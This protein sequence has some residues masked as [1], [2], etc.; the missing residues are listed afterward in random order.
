MAPLD[1]YYLIGLILSNI[2]FFFAL[3]LFHHLISEAFDP[4]I[5]KAGLLY[6]AFYRYAIFFFA[7]YTESLFLLLCLGIFLLLRSQQMRYWWLAGVLGF[8]AT[9]TRSTGIVLMV[10]ILIVALQRYW[11]GTQFHKTSWWQKLHALAP[12]LLVPLGLVTYMAY[13]A[14]TKVFP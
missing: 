3:V 11:L 9:L 13:L 7:G 10:P 4:S 8:L 14:A 6:L 2:F 5:A 1:A 12:V